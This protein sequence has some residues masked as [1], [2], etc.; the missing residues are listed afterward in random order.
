MGFWI[1]MMISDLII[2]FTMI[3]LGKFFIKNTPKEING[4]FGYRTS[5]SRK[6]KDTWEFAH[7]Y[8][9]KLWVIIGWIMIALSVIVMLFVIGKDKN[10]VGTF[11]GI[12]CG[13][14]VI[15]LVGSIFPT[16]KALKINF[17]KSGNRKK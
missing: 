10:V 1:F 9:G 17:D 12:L 11:G 3:G 4:V 7:N 16:E 14:Q 2:P 13:I 15:L 8:C 5:M 6:N